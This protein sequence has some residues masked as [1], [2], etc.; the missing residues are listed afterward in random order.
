M[1]NGAL[2]GV[3][4]R[5]IIAVIGGGRDV[6]A[7]CADR[8]EELG[9]WIASRGWHLL[10]GGGPGTM[11]AAARGFCSI[12]PRAGLSIGVIPADPQRPGHSKPGYPNPWIELA[13]FT[14]LAGEDPRGPG[15]R[16]H[17]N[18]L[19]AQAVVALP[20]ESGT[21]AEVDLAGRLYRRPLVCW[22]QAEEAIHGLGSLAL[23]QQ[24]VAV[25]SKLAEVQA[26]VEQAV[27][28]YLETAVPP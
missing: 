28:E 16:N 20:G 5:P 3:P 18:I 17:I 8:A 19:T 4:R 23:G 12:W 21:G 9:R 24:H 7:S 25:T 22:L 15:S 2:P 6:S 27:R 1:T 10:T 13:I 26:V 14:H 11:A